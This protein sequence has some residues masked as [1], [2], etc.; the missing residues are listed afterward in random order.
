MWHLYFILTDQHRYAIMNYMST[1]LPYTFH[2]NMLSMPFLWCHLRMRYSQDYWL[3]PVSDTLQ[4]KLSISFTGCTQVKQ[5]LQHNLRQKLLEWVPS[6]QQLIVGKAQQSAVPYISHKINAVTIDKD[7]EKPLQ[8]SSIQQL[9]QKCKDGG[10]AII[11]GEA[12]SG[13]TTALQNIVLWWLNG[14][15][16]VLQSYDFVFLIPLRLVQ[17]HG[18]IDII[19]LD[20]QLLPKEFGDSLSRTLAMKSKQVLFLLDSY[21]ELTAA[22]AEELTK[23]INRDLNAQATVLI[24]SRPGSHLAHIE[25]TPCIRAQL[26]NFSEEDVKEYTAH[27]SEGDQEILS[28]IEKKFGMDFLERPINLALACYIYMSLGTKGLDHVTQTQLFGQIVLQLLMVYI[29][30]ESRVDVSLGNVLELFSTDDRR[31]TGA[32]VLFKE[33]CRLCHETIQNGTKWLSTV[34]IDITVNDLMNFGLFFPGPEP[35][36]IDLPHRLFQEYLAAVYLVRSQ[37]AWK[38]LF[39]QIQRE[40]QQS[41]SR[42][43]LGDVLRSMGLENVVRFIVGLSASHGHDLCKLFVVKQQRVSSTTSLFMDCKQS[44]YSYELTLLRELGA[45][46]CVKSSMAEALIN[47]PVITVSAVRDYVKNSGGEQLMDILNP[48]QSRH[49]L[50][51][52]YGCEVKENLSGQ[53]TMSMANDVGPF[54][55]DSFVVRCLQ[56]FHC[57]ALQVGD[58]YVRHSDIPVDLLPLLVTSGIWENLYIQDCKLLPPEDSVRR[59]EVANQTQSLVPKVEVW[60]RNVSGRRQLRDCDITLPDVGKLWLRGCGD[61]DIWELSQTFTQLWRLEV[62]SDNR[63]VYSDNWKSLHMMKELGLSCCGEAKL[64]MLSQLCPQL[65]HLKIND[66]QVSWPDVRSQWLLLRELKLLSLDEV[67]LSQWTQLCPCLERLCIDGEYCVGGCAVCVDD[68]DGRLQSLQMLRLWYSCLF[69]R[70]RRLTEEEATHTLTHICPA[71]TIDVV[72]YQATQCTDFTQNK[73]KCL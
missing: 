9:L 50:A 72:C 60:L 52:A 29:K 51:K 44:V 58:M 35:N 10:R 56:K 26:Q 25:P 6:V 55:Y 12:G 38:A 61:V 2:L 27:Y 19:C 68:V 30:K 49:F 16:A 24:T 32:K 59:L 54:V 63:L 33:I 41:T 73:S 47:A 37:P 1:P 70:G 14:Q 28:D 7:G 15:M 69:Q 4:R 62:Y 3:L 22:R 17:C 48:E 40:C 42:R 66:C 64:C 71:A 18:I 23:L 43:Y 65:T 21:E 5:K 8:V 34:D 67:K 20:C 36:T 13:K 39:T 45:D 11:Y 57:T 53:V 31:L 46:D